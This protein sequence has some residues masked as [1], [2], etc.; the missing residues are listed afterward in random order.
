MRPC[1]SSARRSRRRAVSTLTSVNRLVESL[2]PRRLL[3]VV[4]WDG[5]GNGTDWFDPLN[6]ST[7]Q[8]PGTNDDVSSNVAANPTILLDR[9][10]TIRSLSN[11]ESLRI[12]GNS[13]NGSA[14]LSVSAGITNSGSIELNST[15]SSWNSTI[16]LSG[17]TFTNSATGSLTANPGTGGQRQITLQGTSAFTNAGAITVANSLTLPVLGVG[18]AS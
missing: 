2:E 18:A 14:S 13:S 3:A 9:T 7:D 6:W 16:T 1:R 5:G 17:G 11:S 4:A 15:G 10:T 12:V 8:V